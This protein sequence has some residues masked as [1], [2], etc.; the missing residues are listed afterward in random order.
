MLQF[1]AAPIRNELG[2][3]YGP[4][5]QGTGL[6]NGLGVVELAYFTDTSK[7][8]GELL[9]PTGTVVPVGF[10]PQMYNRGT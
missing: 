3:A 10:C 6:V 9:G 5:E 4:L 1:S 8:A 7:T 2:V